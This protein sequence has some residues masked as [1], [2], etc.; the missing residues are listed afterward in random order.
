M[1]TVFSL[2]FILVNGLNSVQHKDRNAF[3]CSESSLFYVPGLQLKF[4]C[5]TS[6]SILSSFVDLHQEEN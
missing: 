6:V 2:R 3:F 4:E 5:S 1:H